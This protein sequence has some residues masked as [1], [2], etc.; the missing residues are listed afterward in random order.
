MKYLKRICAQFI[1]FLHRHFQLCSEIPDNIRETFKSLKGYGAKSEDDTSQY[2]IDSAVE[3][4]LCDSF[5]G[6]GVQFFRNPNNKSPAEEFELEKNENLPTK[7]FIVRAEDRAECTDHLILLMQQFVPCRFQESDRRGG[8]NSRGRDRPI[9]FPG[10]VC[11]HCNKKRYFPIAAKNFSDTHN[12]MVTHIGNCF[13]VPFPIKASLSYL[14]HRSIL[15]KAELPN[16]Y[17]LC[18]FKRIWGRLHNDEWPNES[19]DLDSAPVVD[20]DAHDRSSEEEGE[21]FESYGDTSKVEEGTNGE[22]N[23][24]HTLTMGETEEAEAVHDGLEEMKDLIKAAAIWL[25]ERDA[26]LDQ[27]TRA[28][29]GRGTYL[30]TPKV[31]GRGRG[32]RGGRGRVLR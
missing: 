26:E 20:T 29:R 31:A 15:Q 21:D 12:L 2:W 11:A 19:E 16:N 9:G 25:C 14:Q 32:G 22:G 6:Q 17:K 3:L 27:R 8:Q 28:G 1:L 13:N 10:L 4:G 23:M 5:E 18:F 7:S 24:T 30:L